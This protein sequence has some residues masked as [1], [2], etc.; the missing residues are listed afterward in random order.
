M[1]KKHDGKTTDIF[2]LGVI[3][4]VVIKGRPPFADAST[5]D[6]HYSLIRSEKTDEFWKEIGG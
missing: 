2:A 3:L 6:P 1:K 5:K 4:F